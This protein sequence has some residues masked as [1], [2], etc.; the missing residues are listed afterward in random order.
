[1]RFFE[2]AKDGGSESPVDAYFLFEIKPLFSIAMLKF[3]K[4]SRENYHTHAFNA[5]TWFICGDLVE[6]DVSGK[7]YKYGRSLIP[8]ITLKEKNHRVIAAETSWCLTLRGKWCGKWTEYN[9]KENKTITM[10]NGR[11]VISER[12]GI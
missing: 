4:G 3:N 2:K 5:F 9:E 11:K 8:K 10:T 12:Y 6:Q 7:L 1:M